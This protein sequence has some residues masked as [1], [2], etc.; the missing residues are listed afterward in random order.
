VANNLTFGSS[1]SGI[2]FSGNWAYATPGVA[3]SDVAVCPVAGNGSLGACKTAMTFGSPTSLAVS[4]GRLYVAD[5]NG[6]GYVHSCDINNADGSLS[7]C[8]DNAVGAINTMDGVS[9]TATTAYI[10]DINGNNLT[11]CAVS[12]VDGTLSGCS[13]QTLNNTTP[14]GGNT[15]VAS[16][17]SVKA[18]GGN[19]YIGTGAGVLL[20]PI[21]SD[22][23]VKVTYP[24]PYSTGAGVTCVDD[25]VPLQTP[26]TGI[27]F[28]NGYAYVSGYGNSGAG[29]V[30]VCKVEA[31]GYLDQCTTSA[32][33]GT[34]AYYG[35][36]AV[37]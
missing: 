35:A 11:T 33:P 20:L 12:A 29:G 30:A 37:H 25:T 15:P 18:Y 7:N 10:V 8:H 3:G 34:P 5:A 27:A 2:A 32:T 28:N 31:T 23:S 26:L 16:P 24:C 19:L 13:Q 1:A 6:P 9:V 21:Q 14:M 4:G 22:G 36:L 17:R